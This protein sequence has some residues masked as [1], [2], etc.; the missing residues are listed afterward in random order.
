MASCPTIQE[1]EAYLD[2][3]LDPA[4]AA[5]IER[6][7]TACPLCSA[8]YARVRSTSQLFANTPGP[9]LSQISLH[10]LHANLESVIRQERDQSVV[11]IARIF[12][13]LAA[14]IV[15]AGSLW[16]TRIHDKPAQAAPPWTDVAFATDSDA[17]NTAP[18]DGMAIA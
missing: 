1:L 3:E 5:L 12:S 11:R 7:L 8:E 14:C 18:A 9:R 10:R 13:A 6:H 4:R 16:L 2:C 17:G 15:V